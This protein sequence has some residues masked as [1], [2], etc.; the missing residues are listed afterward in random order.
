MFEA[1]VIP[2][3]GNEVIINL[4]EQPVFGKCFAFYPMSSYGQP[5]ARWDLI[6]CDN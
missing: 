3:A 4:F 1:N 2:D 6:G 5:I